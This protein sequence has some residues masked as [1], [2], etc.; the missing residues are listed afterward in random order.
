MM[1]NGFFLLALLFTFACET[2]DDSVEGIV[3]G[4]RVGLTIGENERLSEREVILADR[5][6]DAMEN[7][8]DEED[9]FYGNYNFTSFYQVRGGCNN[10]SSADENNISLPLVLDED[11]FDDS[12]VA[13]ALRPHA[14]FKFETLNRN[15]GRHKF[16]E[17]C[18]NF[19]NGNR[20]RVL[21]K[22][23]KRRAYWFKDGLTDANIGNVVNVIIEEGDGNNNY[24]VSRSYRLRVLTNLDPLSAGKVDLY[25]KQEHCNYDQD[26]FY[27]F[28]ATLN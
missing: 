12:A 25:S 3:M 8:T 20:L 15:Q 27:K 2:S 23:T 18:Q 28:T 26:S 10:H 21:S 22:S 4:A 14:Y 9:S 24:R 13:V 6:C 16:N 11:G 5:F 19:E 7:I 17:F 1:K